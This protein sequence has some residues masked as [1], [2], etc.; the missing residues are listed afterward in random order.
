MKPMTVMRS[1]RIMKVMKRPRD[2][3]DSETSGHE[4]EE[5]SDVE[6]SSEEALSAIKVSGCKSMG[7]TMHS[8][9]GSHDDEDDE[10]EEVSGREESEQK[11]EK[12]SRAEARDVDANA[13]MQEKKVAAEA[14]RDAAKER[15]QMIRMHRVAK[16]ACAKAI[17]DERRCLQSL[18]MC[19]K[20]YKPVYKRFV[21]TEQVASAVA[22]RRTSSLEVLEEAVDHHQAAVAKVA[23]AT[24]FL[25][26][27]LLPKK[28]KNVRTTVKALL[29]SLA[30]KQ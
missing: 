16:I 2:D 17:K 19:E 11:K 8:D 22:R 29:K 5:T 4:S 25:T 28:A 7:M 27:N 23:A 21:K 13:K 1:M 24:A 10:D 26:Q 30:C 15:K 9:D 20:V 18:K 6:S 3:S 12:L 14:K